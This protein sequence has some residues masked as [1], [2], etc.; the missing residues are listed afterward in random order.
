MK[1][2]PFSKSK[3]EF[4]G[5][6]LYYIRDGILSQLEEDKPV[7]ITGSRG[8]G[9]TTLLNALNWREQISNESLRVAIGNGK[10]SEY[11]GVYIK[12][13]ETKPSAFE[14]WSEVEPSIRDELFSA[15]LDL[16]WLEEVFNGLADLTT[17]GTLNISPEDEG[18]I[19]KNF[20][21]LLSKNM[22]NRKPQD[23]D[24]TF[25]GAASACRK[26]WFHIERL[27]THHVSVSPDTEIFSP[28]SQ[29]GSFGREAGLYL[30][31]EIERSSGLEGYHFKICFD[32]CECLSETQVKML[33]TLVRLA[34][35]PCYYVFSF[36][37]RPVDLSGTI[38]PSLSNQLADR[39]IVELDNMDDQE[40]TNFAQGVAAVRIQSFSGKKSISFEGEKIF[41]KISIN[42]FIS[43]ILEKSESPSAQK[44]I[45]S[46]SEVKRNPFFHL[47]KEHENPYYQNYLVEQLKIELVEDNRGKWTKARR[48]QESK[49]I[50]KK[51][52]A[53]YLSICRDLKTSPIYAS[54]DVI[55][56]I[57]DRSIRDFLLLMQELYLE[58]G[59]D[60]D[61]FCSK[62]MPIMKQNSG[63]QSF[64][65]KKFESLSSAPSTKTGSVGN[66]VYAVGIITAMI[67]SSSPDKSHLRSPERG[68]FCI[69]GTGSVDE[70]ELARTILEATEAGFLKILPKESHDLRFRLHTSLSP[71]F[72]TSYRGSYYDYPVQKIEL[73]QILALT[74]SNEIK[75]RCGEIV[76][77]KY[78]SPDQMSLEG[79]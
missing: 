44:L 15:Y 73:E 74:S 52:V 16:I 41:G 65:K 19:C 32:E 11:L 54:W 9:K 70:C 14:K 37:S 75:A 26:E 50:R 28:G 66:I 7:V 62:K 51:M 68:K 72:S 3:Y 4:N 42:E 13:S 76:S 8:T 2:S 56:Q 49:E 34:K 77:G 45:H 48:H 40:F 31:S 20:L 39:I 69:D 63:I 36:I 58:F 5:R 47:Y 30:S 27:A 61:T 38:I 79:L 43:T 53:A 71:Y 67:Q 55:I 64:S 25:R 6:N 78:S 21:C 24:P 33:N 22:I 59:V 17:F 29:V 35:H 57:C 10:T 12:I 18:E 1:Q 23:I 46:T 60:I